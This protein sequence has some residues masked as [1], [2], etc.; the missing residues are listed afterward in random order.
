[1][2]KI[3]EETGLSLRVLSGGGPVDFHRHGIDLAIRRNDFKLDQGVEIE[4]IGNEYMGPVMSLERAFAS[5]STSE[6][7]TRI[8][9]TSR[10][11]SWLKWGQQTQKD[12]LSEDVEYQH[13]FLA[14]EA[15]ESG[16]GIAMM[17][18][19]MVA[20]TLETA[21][22]TAPFGFVA[23]GSKYVCISTRPIDLD[24]R[25]RAFIDWLKQTFYEYERLYLTGD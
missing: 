7:Y 12:I 1:M 11:D 22:L 8:R 5:G 10:P 17:S 24:S 18:L 4:T 16:H 6:N 3:E 25:K 14:L 2:P 23:D 13:H 19:Y 15:A 20:R 21:R 9:S